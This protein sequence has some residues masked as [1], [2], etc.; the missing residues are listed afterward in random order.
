MEGW[1][2]AYDSLTSGRYTLNL[3]SYASFLGSNDTLRSLP[4]VGLCVPL[5]THISS[6]E[7][8]TASAVCNVPAFA[9][10]L[11]SPAAVGFVLT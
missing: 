3:Y 8:E 6:P 5:P 9:Q 4:V 2:P 1:Q 7:A 10:L 11:Q